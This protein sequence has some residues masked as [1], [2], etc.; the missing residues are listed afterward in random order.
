MI[1]KMDDP[2]TTKTKKPSTNGPTRYE[3]AFFT[4]VSGTTP[5]FRMFFFFLTLHFSCLQGVDVVIF[6][7]EVSL[8]R[9]DLQVL[10]AIHKEIAKYVEVRKSLQSKQPTKPRMHFQRN[11]RL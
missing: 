9:F 10:A 11:V 3:L 5:L 1:W 7:R 4:V 8:P 6:A 2:I